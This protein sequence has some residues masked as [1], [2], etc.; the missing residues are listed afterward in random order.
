MSSPT[1]EIKASAKLPSMPFPYLVTLLIL[2]PFVLFRSHSRLVRHNLCDAVLVDGLNARSEMRWEMGFS[3]SEIASTAFSNPSLQLIFCDIG[4]RLISCLI[5]RF[6]RLPD[7]RKS[8][9][10]IYIVNGQPFTVLRTLL[11]LNLTLIR[12]LKG[13][14]RNL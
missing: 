10:Y 8:G 7:S 9:G 14:K 3:E 2:L 13:S 5:M 11:R 6:S 1:N 4:L 12:I